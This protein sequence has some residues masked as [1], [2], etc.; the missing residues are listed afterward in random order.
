MSATIIVRICG[1][2]AGICESHKFAHQVFVS[3]G[4]GCF[5]NTVGMA[6]N[7]LIFQFIFVLKIISRPF[8]IVREHNKGRSEIRAN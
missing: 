8:K 4:F 3:A 5:E 2:S 1:C 6:I 7:S